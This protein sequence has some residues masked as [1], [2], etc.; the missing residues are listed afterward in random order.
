M[1]LLADFENQTKHVVALDF[2]FKK[3]KIVKIEYGLII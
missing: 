2:T 3:K 1:H